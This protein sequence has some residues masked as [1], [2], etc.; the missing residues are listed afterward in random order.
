MTQ[1]IQN[2]PRTSGAE[3]A[4]SSGP[5][6][7]TPLEALAVPEQFAPAI[8]SMLK[9]LPGPSHTEQSLSSKFRGF[10]VGEVRASFK[11]GAA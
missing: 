11:K 4:P 2:K 10:A 9:E 7:A 5:T 6:E 3:Q 8:D 1:D